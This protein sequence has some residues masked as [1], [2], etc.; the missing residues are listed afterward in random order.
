VH[1]FRD[2]RMGAMTACV[3]DGGA[4]CNDGESCSC[5]AGFKCVAAP[6]QDGGRPLGAGE[7]RAAPKPTVKVYLKGASAPAATIP[8]PPAEVMLGSPC[9]MLYAA[10]IAW[11]SLQETGSLPDGGTP[12]ATITD[13]TDAGF[14]RFGKRQPGDLRQCSPDDMRQWYNRQ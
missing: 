4:D 8:L 10:D 1:Y 13:R 6:P 2:Y 12:P 7:C 3:A 9:A 5:A 14:A 11:P